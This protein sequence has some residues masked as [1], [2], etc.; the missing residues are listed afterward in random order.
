MPSS[1]DQTTP[2]YKKRGGMLVKLKAEKLLATFTT[3]AW[4]PETSLD[5]V[6]TPCAARP[7]GPR[8][9]GRVRTGPLPAWEGLEPPCAQKAPTAQSSP[10]STMTA[11]HSYEHVLSTERPQT[12]KKRRTDSVRRTTAVSPKTGHRA[13]VLPPEQRAGETAGHTGQLPAQPAGETTYCGSRREHLPAPPRLRDRAP[14]AQGAPPAWAPKH[15]VPVPAGPG[16]RHRAVPWGVG[17]G[18]DMEPTLRP[19]APTFS[20]AI[21]FLPQPSHVRG[22]LGQVWWCACKGRGGCQSLGP[23]CGGRPRAQGRARLD[24]R[25]PREGGVGLHA[26]LAR[27]PSCRPGSR[28]PCSAG[29]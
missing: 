18:R 25:R 4:P 6:L 13:L 21:F 29:S 11:Q 1:R 27:S 16:R 15:Q 5:A 14:R 28:A 17:G 3:R 9:A 10:W 23:G 20:R 2:P 8:L 26:A 12:L 19:R 24:A 22:N 7:E